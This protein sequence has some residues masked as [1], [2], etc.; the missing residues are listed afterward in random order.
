MKTLHASKHIQI[1]QLVNTHIMY[2]NWI[3]PQSRQSVIEGEAF[4]LQ[5][6]A[7]NQFTKVLND[8]T[9]VTGPW[10][11]AVTYTVETWFPAMI[12]SGLQHFAWIFSPNIF[13]QLSAKRAAHAHNVVKAFNE[14]DHALNWLVKRE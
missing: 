7:Q 3:G 9:Q 2:C 12:T 1:T 6:L 5:L 4:M 10:N 11:T 14:Y 13:A 8:N